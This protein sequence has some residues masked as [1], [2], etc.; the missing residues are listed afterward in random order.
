MNQEPA[1]PGLFYSARTLLANVV[2]L[3][4][5]RLDLLSTELQEEM[6]RAAVILFA[7]LTSWFFAAMGIAF[8]ALAVVIAAGDDH[9]L[10]A[11]VILALLFFTCCAA[12]ALVMHRVAKGKSRV[13]D[14]SLS[15]LRKDYDLLKAQP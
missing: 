9:R 4:H 12:G 14:A 2:A 6:A 8:A 5:T 3:A 11:V 13:F 15:E 10:A 7:G 1:S